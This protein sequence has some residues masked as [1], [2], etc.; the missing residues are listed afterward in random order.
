[1]VML[2]S[3][4]CERASP[5]VTS[6]KPFSAWGEIFSADVAAAAMIDR[7]VHHAEIVAL[8]GV[9][10]RLRIASRR[11]R[12]AGANILQTHPTQTSRIRRVG[13]E[14]KTGSFAGASADRPR[15]R[16]LLDQSPRSSTR[17]TS[18]RRRLKASPAC[19]MRTGLLVLAP[20]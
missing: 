9:S 20:R 16:G 17:Q 7:L 14:S 1:M 15:R 8:K 19:N 18:S 2:V 4:R 10:Y 6:N 12:H 5:I 3:S 13:C 11:Y